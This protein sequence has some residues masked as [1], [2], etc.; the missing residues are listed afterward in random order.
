M[1]SDVNPQGFDHYLERIPSCSNDYEVPERATL[2]MELNYLGRMF[3]FHIP[4]QQARDWGVEM[5]ALERKTWISSKEFNHMRFAPVFD[6]IRAL[7]G[8]LT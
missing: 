4:V 6:E 7:L 1:R 2:E 8:L 3:C 5:T